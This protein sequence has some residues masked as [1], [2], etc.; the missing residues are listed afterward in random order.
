MAGPE[1]L[2]PRLF[3]LP[4]SHMPPLQ[5]SPTHHTVCHRPWSRGGSRCP[6]R[7]RGGG[8]GPQTLSHPEV[9][10]HQR[11]THTGGRLQGPD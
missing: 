5:P 1:D 9:L 4:A 11:G 2:W 6:R 10:G 3:P 8:E 7:R